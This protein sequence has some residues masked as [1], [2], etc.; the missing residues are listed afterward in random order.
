M[1]KKLHLNMW[2][3]IFGQAAFEIGYQTLLIGPPARHSTVINC[4]GKYRFL[5]FQKIRNIIK[6]NFQN[7]V[8]SI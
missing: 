1:K 4:L 7:H 6:Y 8:D 2:N 3:R 5:F